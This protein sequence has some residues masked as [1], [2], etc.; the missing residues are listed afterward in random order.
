MLHALK[1]GILSNI[2][3]GSDLFCYPCLKDASLWY[4]DQEKGF[5]SHTFK[6]A[7]MT[8][9]RLKLFLKSHYGYYRAF[10]FWIIF[11]LLIM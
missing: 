5:I 1:S 11:N 8:Q 6:C 2:R 9:M 3:Y 7:I 10:F 4:G